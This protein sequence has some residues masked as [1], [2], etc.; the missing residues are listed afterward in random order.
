MTRGSFNGLSSDDGDRRF[1]IV[2]FVHWAVACGRSGIVKVFGCRPPDGGAARAEA[3]VRK[4][5]QQRP[6]QERAHSANLKIAS[7]SLTIH[8][9]S[10]VSFRAIGLRVNDT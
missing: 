6:F 3:G 2:R 5:P 9:C 1:A 10:F 8:Q 7:R 4:P